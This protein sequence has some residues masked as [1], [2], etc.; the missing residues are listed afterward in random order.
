MGT[1]RLRRDRGAAD[2]CGRGRRPW[3]LA[4]AHERREGAPRALHAAAAARG[5]RLAHRPRP[6]LLGRVMACAASRARRASPSAG[7]GA[8]RSAAAR[9]AA[10]GRASRPTG[11]RSTRPPSATSASGRRCAVSTARRAR[12][13]APR[14][15]RASRAAASGRASA[16]SARRCSPAAAGRASSRTGARCIRTSCR[17]RTSSR[18]SVRR[19]A[20]AATR[21]PTTCRSGS[22]R[23]MEAR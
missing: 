15:A 3:R 8:A 9:S 7:G 22:D 21:R 1:L 14:A 5:R 23:A 13:T 20:V 16:R 6:H 18:R 11:A 12:P 17:T 2:G 19:T 10:A 4:P